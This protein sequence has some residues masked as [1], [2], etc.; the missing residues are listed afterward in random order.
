MKF[1]LL[2]IIT[3]ISI[4]SFN[5]QGPIGLTGPQGPKG[6]KGDKGNSA[7]FYS[8]QGILYESKLIDNNHWDIYLDWI[9]DTTIIQCWIRQGAGYMWVK[10]IWYMSPGCIRIINNFNSQYE[11]IITGIN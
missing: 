6:N 5:C 11:Y 4:I 1:K 9:N 7:N 2:I 8:S 3:I 10:P